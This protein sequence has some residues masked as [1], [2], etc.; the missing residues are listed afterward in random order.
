MFEIPTTTA[1]IA[2]PQ[3]IVRSDPA[4]AVDLLSRHLL[5]NGMWSYDL[6][7]ASHDPLARR[8]NECWDM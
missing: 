5:I 6:T 2:R 3:Y 1:R 4:G 7:T 8:H